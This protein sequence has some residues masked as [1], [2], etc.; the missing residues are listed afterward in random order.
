VNAEDL[1]KLLTTYGPAGVSA[2][3][4]TWGMMER[5][6]RQTTQAKYDKLAETLPSELLAIVRETNETL[7]RWTAV[8]E[9]ALRRVTP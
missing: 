9:S 3:A 5:K 2:L 7:S 6:E 4:I 8:A 1:A